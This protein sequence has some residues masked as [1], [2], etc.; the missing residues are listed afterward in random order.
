MTQN[1]LFTYKF[2]FG[3]DQKIERNDLFDRYGINI[4]GLAK[5][6][7]RVP[8]IERMFRKIEEITG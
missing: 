3:E 1:K 4:S 8:A 5:I 2:Y 7:A 6:M